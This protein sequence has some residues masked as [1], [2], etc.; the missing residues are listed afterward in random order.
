[1]RN[2]QPV[3]A[4]ISLL[5]GGED[6]NARTKT[7]DVA[8]RDN[9]WRDL[10]WK[11]ARELNCLPSAVASGND[12]LIAAARRL[13]DGA[14][15]F[16]RPL[17]DEQILECENFASR[18]ARSTRDL[19]L[20]TVRLAS[21]VESTPM[22]VA[23][24]ARS[25]GKPYLERKPRTGYAGDAAPTTWMERFREAMAVMCGGKMPPL[26]MCEQWV[27][28]EQVNGV[29]LLQEWVID[30]AAVAVSWHTGIG[31]I[32]AAKVWADSPEEG[33]GHEDREDAYPRL[34]DEP[35]DAAQERQA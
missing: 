35:E 11:L 3:S 13:V 4:G 15:A 23:A 1:V 6:V 5:L 27:R 24:A 28:N 19:T 8:A 31:A 21:V 22:T 2:A 20:R 25:L 34:D 14:P 10:V 33:V 29:D 16:R 9:P 12:H 18:S 26:D 7:A 32:E 17:S 30:H